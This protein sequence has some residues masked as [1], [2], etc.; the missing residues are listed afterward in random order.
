MCLAALSLSLFIH[1][2]ELVSVGSMFQSFQ[3]NLIL[4]AFVLHLG[5]LHFKEAHCREN[6]TNS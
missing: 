3:L 4:I 6:I 2:C 1:L 5:S